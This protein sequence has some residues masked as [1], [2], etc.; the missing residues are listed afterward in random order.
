MT[1][2]SLVALGQDGI[3]DLDLDSSALATVTALAHDAYRKR[4]PAALLAVE[5]ALLR[6]SIRWAFLPPAAGQAAV[7]W[8]LLTSIRMQTLLGSCQRVEPL[9]FAT[10]ATRLQTLVRD[11]GVHRHPLLDVMTAESARGTLKRWAHCFYAMTFG[12]DQRIV[13]AGFRAPLAARALCLHNVADEHGAESHV[14]LRQR[15]LDSIGVAH[16]V[17]VPAFVDDLPIEALELINTRTLLSHLH[18]PMWSLGCL[19][20]TEANW[21]PE[22]Q[23]LN[24]LLRAAGHTAHATDVFYTHGECDAAHASEWLDVIRLTADSDAARAEVVQGAML[25][26]ELKRRMYD[27]LLASH[28]AALGTPSGGLAPTRS[29]PPRPRSDDRPLRSI[30]A[31]IQAYPAIL[32]AH[33]LGIY[34]ALADGP[35]THEDLAATLSL[36]PRA[37][38]ALI[39][40][41]MSLGT[42]RYDAD[43]VALTELAE[44]YLLRRSETYFGHYFDWLASQPEMFS[45][46][47]IKKSLQHDRPEVYGKTEAIFQQHAQDAERAAAFTRWMHGASMAPA[48]FWPDHVDLSHAI[49]FVDV[50][51]GSGAHCIGAARRYPSLRATVLDLPPVCTVARDYIAR[52]GMQERV[53][54][55][56]F[57]MFRDAFPPGDVYFF[58]HIFHDWS[59]ADCLELARKSLAALRP[60]GQI[61]IHEL[62]WR[63]DRSG[64]FEVAAINLLM[65]LLYDHGRQWTPSELASIL[66][67]AG[68]AEVETRPTWGFWGLAIGRKRP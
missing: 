29:G 34:E 9:D 14:A 21:A 48:L 7:L 47:S 45:V 37:T 5:R 67:E 19:Y 24:P 55:R 61:L 42:L 4:Q 68:F 43:R 8:T 23:R 10:A 51:G 53:S 63:D 1:I 35:R 57:D 17:S 28:S 18:R 30:V 59:R 40:V 62:F 6:A 58:S 66:E 52:A 49:D 56:E 32:V 36:A 39:A 20:V 60:G 50:A 15:F 64:P 25:E 33:S 44:D 13:L 31:G 22:C 41:A 2:A 46:A 38:S 54:T 26:I 27:A 11:Q 12:F 3:G 65:S 16:D